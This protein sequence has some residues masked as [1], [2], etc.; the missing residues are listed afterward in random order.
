MVR[1]CT[2]SFFR[3]PGIRQGARLALVLF[4][5]FDQ[6]QHVRH[7]LLI[8]LRVRELAAAQHPG[9]VQRVVDHFPAA[10]KPGMSSALN[11]LT[12]RRAI[13]CACDSLS[14]ARAM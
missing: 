10:S 4:A 8:Q 1:R 6:V 13:S 12:V 3:D 7:G 11:R 5:D 14:Q 9:A 2:P